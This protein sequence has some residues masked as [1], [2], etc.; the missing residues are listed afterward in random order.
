MV[1]QRDYSPLLTCAAM[2]WVAVNIPIVVAAWI[3]PLPLVAAV[4]IPA[5]LYFLVLVFFAVRTVFGTDNRIAA[6][7]ACVWGIALLASTLLWNPL[8]C[9]FALLTSPFHRLF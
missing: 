5:Y 7:V 6:G 4:S 3:L 8:S 2:A 1:F 9:L